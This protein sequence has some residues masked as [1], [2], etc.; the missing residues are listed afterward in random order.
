MEKPVGKSKHVELTL[1]QLVEVQPGLARLMR[2]VGDAYWPAYYAAK[3]RNWPLARYFVKRTESLMKLAATLRPKYQK[4]L[5]AYVS[6]SLARLHEAVEA[7]D[8]P[9]F[10]AAYRKGIEVANRMHE[11]TGHP[12]IVWKLPDFAPPQLDMAPRAAPE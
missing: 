2:E 12:E 4:E 6:G 5:D 10:E 3:A 11:A 7:R 9:R 8:W 1:D